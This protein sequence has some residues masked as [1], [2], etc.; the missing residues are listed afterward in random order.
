VHRFTGPLGPLKCPT[1]TT[2]HPPVNFSPKH[3]VLTSQPLATLQHATMRHKGQIGLVPLGALLLCLLGA[4][5]TD[6]QE[7]AQ[8]TANQ[9]VPSR[10]LAKGERSCCLELSS[11]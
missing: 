5:L 7:A 10:N 11:L 8:G 2:S 3:F 9:N 4:L 1:S 6:A